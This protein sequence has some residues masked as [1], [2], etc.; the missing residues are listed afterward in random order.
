MTNAVSSDGPVVSP[1]DDEEDN[2]FYDCV[3]DGSQNASNANN[4]ED[5]SFILNIPVQGHRRNSSDSSGEEDQGTKQVLFMTSG[6]N[7]D[8]DKEGQ[9]EDGNRPENAGQRVRR[10]RV[11]EKRNHPLNLWSIMKNCIG[12]DL[13]KIPMPVNFS[14]PL[15]MLQRLTEDYEYAEVLDVAAA[16]DDPCEQLAHVAAFTVSS[17]STTANRTGK[18]FN[19]LLGE[20]FECDR[21]DDLGWR[22]ISEQVSHHPPMVAQFC[23][24]K[25][26][27]CWQEF[28]MTS[29]FRG[30][31]LQ[32]TNLFKTNLYSVLLCIE[33]DHYRL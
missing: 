24:G 2:E 17:Y 7:Q 16:C 19:P 1:S 22:S 25:R 32:V 18:P 4:S 21:T 14:E 27:K 28:T 23:E 33:N 5:N 10:Q 6:K 11:P 12:K 15:S 30:K 26:W 8:K 20:T 9:M 3:T 31:Y 29:K 13:S